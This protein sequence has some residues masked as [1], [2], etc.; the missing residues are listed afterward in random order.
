M[1]N[2]EVGTIG[3]LEVE[4]VAHGDGVGAE[5]VDG[6]PMT[7]SDAIVDGA[8]EIEGVPITSIEVEG[9]GAEEVGGVRRKSLVGGD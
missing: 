9:V 7:S 4:G 5:E 6:V 8:E 3:P 1:R 2:K